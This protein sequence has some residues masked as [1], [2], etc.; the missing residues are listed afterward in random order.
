MEGCECQCIQKIPEGCALR[1]RFFFCFGGFAPTQTSVVLSRLRAAAR[2]QHLC[3]SLSRRRSSLRLCVALLPLPPPPQVPDVSDAPLSGCTFAWRGICL[4]DA[5]SINRG[6]SAAERGRFEDLVHLLLRMR[7]HHFGVLPFFA[8]AT[9]VSAA[10]FFSCSFCR[11]LLSSAQPGRRG[12]KPRL[13]K[14]MTCLA[15]F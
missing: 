2:L 5:A 9:D 6:L 14:A 3:E 12:S 7:F 10:V 4:L 8:L 11:E 1:V 15:S 13:Q